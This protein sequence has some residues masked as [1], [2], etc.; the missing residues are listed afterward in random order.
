MMQGQRGVVLNAPNNEVCSLSFQHMFALALMA[1]IGVL[2]LVFFIA[3]RRETKRRAALTAQERK[4]L[5]ESD[6]IWSQHF[7]F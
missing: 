2:F 3:G 6:D 1:G 4:S 7:G 5:E